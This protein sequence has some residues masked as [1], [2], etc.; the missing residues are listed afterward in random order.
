MTTID[1]V[2][3]ESMEAKENEQKIHV[4]QY[5]VYTADAGEHTNHASEYREI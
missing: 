4:G 1:S 2:D 5:L 3:Y